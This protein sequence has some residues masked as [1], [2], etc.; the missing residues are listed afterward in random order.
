MMSQQIDVK[1]KCFLIARSLL[2]APDPEPAGL[3]A[4]LSNYQDVN[5]DGRPAPLPPTSLSNPPD[6]ECW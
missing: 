2:Q 1:R 3:Q 6:Y 5:K 4:L